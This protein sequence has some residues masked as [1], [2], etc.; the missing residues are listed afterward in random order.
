MSGLSSQ[1][2]EQNTAQWNALED[3][4]YIYSAD[5]DMQCL[6]VSAPLDI[7]RLN[8]QDCLGKSLRYLDQEIAEPRVQAI[9][10]AIASS[11]T[12]IYEYTHI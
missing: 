6:A 10:Q 3:T 9:Q 5:D 8:K 2:I 7:R 11:E 12:V 4:A 1:W